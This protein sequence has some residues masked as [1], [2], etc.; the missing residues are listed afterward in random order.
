[1]NLA[2]RMMRTFCVGL[3]SSCSGQSS[4]SLSD[5]P[6]DPV[7]ISTRSAT[8]PGHPIG[9]ILSAASTTWQSYS[10]HQV[11]DLLRDEHRGAQVL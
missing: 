4:I 9:L 3:S 8:E 1:M 7:R 2:K 10:H 5:S 11:F 6:E